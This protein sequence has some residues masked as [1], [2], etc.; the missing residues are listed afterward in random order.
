MSDKAITASDVLSIADDLRWRVPSN[1]REKLVEEIYAESASIAERNV[2]R[3]GQTPRMTWQRSLDW[4]LTSRWTGFPIMVGILAVVLW[5]TIEGANVPSAMLDSVL[6]GEGF[7]FLKSLGDAYLPW[8]LSGVLI[9]GMY[10]T[11]AWVVSGY[12]G[13]S[14]MPRVPADAAPT[15]SP[16]SSA[17]RRKIPC[18]AGLRHW[19]PLQTKS[20]CR[21]W[22]L[23]EAMRMSRRRRSL[24]RLR[25][26]GR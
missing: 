20:T 25:A 14:S 10:L 18:A 15:C 3:K 24:G 13:A 21:G 5:L 23:P 6:V 11:A 12:A 4:L 26:R 16:A 7:P 1:A 17:S 2:T 8:W 9:D 19:L 22:V